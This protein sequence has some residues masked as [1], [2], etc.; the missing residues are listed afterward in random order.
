MA[1][2]KINKLPQGF[3][4]RNGNVVEDNTM[5]DGG[6]TTGDQADYGLVTTPQAYYGET[7]FNNSQDESVRYSLSSVPRE[8]ANIEAEGGETVL[9][10]LNNDGTFGLYDIQGPRHGSGGVPMFLPDQSFIFSDTRKLK[11]TKDEMNEFN[12]GGSK[13]TPAKISKKFGLQDYYAELDSQYADNISATSAELMLKKNMNDLSKLA[14]VQEAKKDFSDGVPLASHP[15][16]VSIGED[17]IEFT[18]KVEEIS[19]KEAEAKAL[20]ALPIEQQ[21]QIMMMQQMMAQQEQQ[22]GMQPQG[23]QQQM[24]QQGMPSPMEEFMPQVGEPGLAM[25][26]NA[27]LGTAMF[28]SELGDFLTKAQEGEEIVYETVDTGDTN[29]GGVTTVNDGFGSYY[30]PPT[31]AAEEGKYYLNKNTG[32]GYQFTNGKYVEV[33][34]V[35]LDSDNKV[36]RPQVEVEETS[37]EVASGPT[38]DVAVEAVTTDK[39]VEA[40]D[41]QVETVVDSGGNKNPYKAGSEKAIKFDKF[42]ADGYTP[43]IVKDGKKSK[44]SFVREAKDG[45]TIKGA[46]E[47]QVFDQD[48]IKG[49]GGLGDTYTP[50]IRAQE[51][52]NNDPDVGDVATFISGKFSGNKLPDTQSR[53][54]DGFGYGSDMFSSEESEEDFYYRNQTVIDELKA[55]GVDFQFNM[56]M[57]DPNYD[58]NW[59]GFQNKYEEKRK[60]YFEKKNVQY[61]PY[62]FTDE[63][64]QERLKNDPDTYDTDGDGKLDK[65]W[66]KRRFDGKRGGYTVNAPGFDMNYQ[67]RDEQFMELDEEPP[68]TK[69]PPVVKPPPKK[70]WWKQDQNNIQALNNIDDELYLPWAPQ[71]EDQ[72]IDYVLDDYTGRVN[73]NLASQNTMAQ[74][75]G[76][77]GP[78]AIARS[79]IQGKTLDANAKAIN[80][81]NQNNVKTMNRVATMQPQL[82]MKVDMAN[83]ATNKQLYD[84]TTVALQN[85]NNFDNWKTGKMNDLYNAGITNAANTYN[86]NQL[87]DYYNVNTLK[88]GDVEFGPNGKKLM[89]DSSGNSAQQNIENYQELQKLMGKDEK[90]NQQ[91]VPEWLFNQTYG[92]TPPNASRTNGQNELLNN[93]GVTGYDAA[94]N[95]VGGARKGKE[96]KKLSKWAV[97]FYSGKMG[98]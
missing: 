76:A 53:N 12:V 18:A 81:V 74:A 67:A 82:D 37:E 87:Y 70:E 20:A 96:I 21:Q 5:K 41:K 44:I 59:R 55:D 13:K 83:N 52:L 6:M 90:G 22:Q 91:Q 71:L 48:K 61:I 60:E 49:A 94:G 80:Q 57:K 46:T 64:L 98:L 65:E 95:K 33:E 27:M 26:N 10:D 85:A 75:L 62:F 31:S 14:F 69:I 97:P 8:D 36:V 19:R 86:M 39:T 9:T 73:A 11:F 58:A 56:D 92:T 66:K 24:P 1:K 43:T 77:Y 7:N 32:Q 16:L 89:K 40:T 17:P 93:S 25:E 72:K 35:T 2:I 50:D 78:Q 30:V 15:Y 79:N 88:G 68:E 45:R 3:S 63:V 4:I 29:D 51:E 28:G 42:I 54:T 34:Q 84:D 23:M 38:N 47:V